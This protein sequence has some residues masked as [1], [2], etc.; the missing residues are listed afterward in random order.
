MRASLQP[1]GLAIMRFRADIT[2]CEMGRD[3]ILSVC[4]CGPDGEIEHELIIQRG[5]KEYDIVDEA[6][7]P[8]I[9]CHDLGLDLSPGPDDI[10]FS[11]GMMTIIVSGSESIEVDISGLSGDEQRELKTVAKAVFE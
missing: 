8:R 4:Q 1:L 11:G 9:S 3:K 6:P 2:T 5:P 10:R 7:G